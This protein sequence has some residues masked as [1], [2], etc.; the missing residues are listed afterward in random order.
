M[1][2]F[3][4]K[5]NILSD[6]WINYRDD[7]QFEAFCNYVDLG[8]PLAYLMDNGFAT[9]SVKGN[10]CIEETFD[11]FLTSCDIQEDVG[12]QT[13]DDIFAIKGIG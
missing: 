1:T 7:E 13:L 2:N 10:E 3:S 5:V 9:A 8:L 4:N 6:L 12:F 11:L